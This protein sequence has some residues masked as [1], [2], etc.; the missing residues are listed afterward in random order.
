MACF[1]FVISFL[2][3]EIFKFSYYENMVIDDV[4]GCASTVV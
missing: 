2:V 3:P 1:L 4:I